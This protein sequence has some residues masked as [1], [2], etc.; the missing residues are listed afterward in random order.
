[1]QD[2]QGDAWHYTL[3]SLSQFF[4]AALAR[5]ESDF[6]GPDG[7]HH[8]FD[9]RKVEIPSHAHESIGSYLDSAH[10]LGRRVADLHLALSSDPLDPQFAPEPFTDHYR[11]AMFHGLMSLDRRNFSALAAALEIAAGRR[12]RATRKSFWIAGR[13]FGLARA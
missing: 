12:R 1:M 11:H 3:D 7:S 9:L 5:K 10:L 4:E 6:S 2:Q 13:I 8:P